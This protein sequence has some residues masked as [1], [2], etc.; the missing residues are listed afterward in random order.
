MN[1]ANKKRKK[2]LSSDAG[3]EAKQRLGWWRANR[4]LMT[5]RCVQLLVIASF[6]SGPWLGIWIFTGNLSSSELF[7]IVP[8]TDPL[9]LTQTMATGHMPVLAAVIGAVIVV[10]VYALLSPRSFCGW[11]CPMNMVTDLAAWLRRK[12]GYNLSLKCDKSLRYFL[13]AG[14]VIGSAVSGAILWGTLDPVSSLHRGIVFGF[15]AGWILVAWVF[16]IDLLLIEHGW[17]GHLCPLGAMHGLISHKSPIRVHVLDKSA[18]T[19]CMDCIHVC[20][21]PQVLRGPIIETASSVTSHDCMSCG[22]CVDVC[23][24]RVLGFEISMGAKDEH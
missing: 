15:G 22:R 24:E 21:E 14:V 5:R 4:F 2:N 6:V 1:L 18:C 17:C 11:V 8:F 23:A 7:G 19:Q 16:V 12:S 10:V 3:K 9:L 13:L 20:P